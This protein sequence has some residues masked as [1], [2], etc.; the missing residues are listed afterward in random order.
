M[1]VWCCRWTNQNQ[2]IWKKITNH[3][4]NKHGER[5][6]NNQM[7]YNLL[8]LAHSYHVLY[9]SDTSHNLNKNLYRAKHFTISIW[10]QV[11]TCM[12]D[13]PKSQK[14]KIQF[15]FI[16]V[17]SHWNSTPLHSEHPGKGAEL[18]RRWKRSKRSN[19]YRSMSDKIIMCR[20]TIGF[21]I[22]FSN[23]IRLF[24]LF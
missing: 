7:K 6:H 4:T 10:S 5:I 20:M 15:I 16:S 12:D 11:K 14:S 19:N 1:C 3:A 22:G 18:S 24:I 21:F 13:F 2:T 9:L 17:Y 23:S 8:H